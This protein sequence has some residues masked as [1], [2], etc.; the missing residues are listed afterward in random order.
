MATASGT[1]AVI[2][3]ECNLPIVAE[4]GAGAV[5]GRTAGEFGGALSRLLS[6][7]AML[8]Q[9]QER[10]FALA[11]DHF[12]WAPILDRLEAIYSSALPPVAT[13]GQLR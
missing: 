7:P 12:G 1:A 5:V 10:A 3:H 4:A 8:A 9:A 11:R 2:S 6:D 13:V